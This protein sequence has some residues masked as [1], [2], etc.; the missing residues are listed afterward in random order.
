MDLSVHRAAQRFKS[1]VQLYIIPPRK[2]IVMS[3]KST[4]QLYI[5]PPR[6]GI[7]MSF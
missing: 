7:V 1:T 4:V 2:G 3:F 6:K 5:I